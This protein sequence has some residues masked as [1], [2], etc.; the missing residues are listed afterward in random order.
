MTT[1]CPGRRVGT[2]AFSTY[3][4]KTALVV[5]P[6]TASDGPMPE[7]VMLESRVTFFPQLCGALHR[8]RL[9]LRDQAYSGRSEVFVEHSSTNTKRLA[10]VLSATRAPARPPSRTRRVLTHPPI[11][12]SAPT[13]APQK[14]RDG[15]LAH[16]QPGHAAEVLAPLGEGGGRSLLEVGLQEPPRALVGLR[17]SA[18]ALLRTQ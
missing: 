10:S 8:A 2:S 16:P 11:F 13:H 17:W 14:P 15:G 18:R 4:S 7:S 5:A 6:S 12:F 9:P 1:T 3:A